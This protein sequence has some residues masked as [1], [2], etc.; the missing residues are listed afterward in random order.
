[1]SAFQAGTINTGAINCAATRQGGQECPLS[2]YYKWFPAYNPP[3]TRLF[4]LAS[5]SDT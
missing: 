3:I 2:K 1:M 5:I 4:S